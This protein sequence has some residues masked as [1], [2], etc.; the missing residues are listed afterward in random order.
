M[1]IAAPSALPGDTLYPVKRAMESVE[2]ELAGDERQQGAALL[3]SASDRLVEVDQ[4]ARRGTPEGVAAVPDTL[5]SFT[6]Q[7]D[8]ASQLLLESY[9]ETGDEQSIT[10][11]RAFTESSMERLLGLEAVVPADARD[12]LR[13][14]AQQL[15][16]IDDLTRRLCPGCPGEG[17]ASIPPVLLSAGVVPDGL[18]QV[19]SAVEPLVPAAPAPQ[20]PPPGAAEQDEIELPDLDDPVDPEGGATGGG[21]P[22]GGA[23][24]GAT[25]GSEDADS[26]TVQDPVR[27][28][29]S[30]LTGGGG[31]SGSGGGGDTTTSGPTKPVTDVLE[32]LEQTVDDTAGTLDDTVDGTTGSLLD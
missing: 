23:D 19:P 4:L 32:G 2:A 25:G 28:L 12:E 15:A 6:L 20:P 14:A 13:T 31:G 27:E 3:D 16:A 11:L 7:S 18:A 17:I 5:T 21:T 26:P 22:G 30:V 10:D 8:Q 29:T 24:D 1:A 9:R